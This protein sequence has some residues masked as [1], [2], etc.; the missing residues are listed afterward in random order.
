M[1]LRKAEILKKVGDSLGY[2]RAL[3]G[4]LDIAE[5]LDDTRLV[6]ELNEKLTLEYG[7]GDYL[8][9]RNLEAKKRKWQSELV[10]ESGVYALLDQSDG[11]LTFE[12][13]Y[14]EVI[15][16]FLK[17]KDDDDLYDSFAC[18]VDKKYPNNEIA[19]SIYENLLSKGKCSPN[20]FVLLREKYSSN[21][22][23]RFLSKL[24]KIRLDN[25]TDVFEELLLT[26]EFFKEDLS[27]S[28]KFDEEML[29]K[30]LTQ[31]TYDLAAPVLQKK[32]ISYEG[33]KNANGLVRLLYLVK[34]SALG[35]LRKRNVYVE[36]LKPLHKLKFQGKQNVYGDFID[37]IVIKS[38]NPPEL[39]EDMLVQFND[40]IA[41]ST[42]ADLCKIIFEDPYH[43]I[44]LK[45]DYFSLLQ[46]QGDLLPKFY[47]KA[48]SQEDDP[49][50]AISF[51][52][53]SLNSD[54]V[55]HDVIVD[56][57]NSIL[58]QPNKVKLSNLDAIKR[59]TEV[60]NLSSVLES[61]CG[62]WILQDVEQSKKNQI[63]M[64]LFSLWSKKW[65]EKTR[66][67][68]LLSKLKD[69]NWFDFAKDKLFAMIGDFGRDVREEVFGQVISRN[70][71]SIDELDNEFGDYAWYAGSLEENAL[72]KLDKVT[73]VPRLE[74]YLQQMSVSNSI[75]RLNL[76]NPIIS[77]LMGLSKGR[78]ASE[79]VNVLKVIS[80]KVGIDQ[81]ETAYSDSVTKCVN[82]GLM[83]YLDIWKNLWSHLGEPSP[84]SCIFT[85]ILVLHGIEYGYPL[86]FSLGAITRLDI[87]FSQRTANLKYSVYHALGETDLKYDL[88][89]RD[90]Q[91]V[92]VS[93]NQMS[94]SPFTE[95]TIRR[96]YDNLVGQ[97]ALE[98]ES[99]LND[100][101]HMLE[102][103]HGARDAIE[104]SDVESKADAVPSYDNQV[105]ESEESSTPAMEF[106]LSDTDT[107]VGA[108]TSEVPSVL[109]NLDDDMSE[110][111]YEVENAWGDDDEESIKT[112]M[113]SSIITSHEAFPWRERVKNNSVDDE[114]VLRLLK[115]SNP[116]LDKHLGL[117]VISMMTGNSEALKNWPMAVWR[118]FYY[119]YYSKEV[120]PRFPDSAISKNIVTPA[121]KSI[122]ELNA[123]FVRAFSKKLVKS[124]LCNI[125]GVSVNEIENNREKLE[126]NEGVLDRAGLGLF[127][128]I[129]KSKKYL[130]YSIK[131]LSKR[132][133]YDANE[134]AFYIDKE[135]YNSVPPSHLL[136]RILEKYWAIRLRYFAFME[137]HPKL[138]VK[139][140]L[141][142]LNDELNKSSFS[143]LSKQSYYQKS[144]A[145]F[146]SS[147]GRKEVEN[148]LQPLMKTS[149]EEITSIQHNFKAHLYKIVLA[150]TLDFVG[151]CESLSDRNLIKSPVRNVQELM[152]LSRYIQPLIRFSLKMTLDDTSG[153]F[154]GVA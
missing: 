92:I 70:I 40:S 72:G 103:E 118:N 14:S 20:A 107:D 25:I 151:V 134:K 43:V 61:F 104:V 35:Y 93:S 126:W 97:F 135:Y 139:K 85:E 32:I 109:G 105:N 117:Q 74:E 17:L 110:S 133:F 56:I 6:H 149:S 7:A 154:T 55:N 46:D 8:E 75:S 26:E 77:K 140:A 88:L 114:A 16:T 38:E 66:A 39:A 34:S 94:D 90:I 57:L 67:N 65:D 29:T 31:D 47:V 128:D 152:G 79:I 138:E 144:A 80:D 81:L 48:A 119:A 49:N 106:D 41:D 115:A 51:L 142:T 153:S 19:V 87:D 21:W 42:K 9:R 37:E 62:Y 27:Y 121:A 23:K 102:G 69:K 60:V 122:V 59:L 124:G 95:Q 150:Q 108:D 53:K 129:L 113:H 36:I 146:I 64:T 13:M 33:S 4:C 78:N 116:Q 130:A 24:F 18:E 127:G 112:G 63:R 3:E 2:L 143:I 58:E 15:L 30:I 50:K 131:G 120:E 123:Y 83:D 68:W 99:R 147:Y 84:F 148:L 52:T 73:S 71:F 98:E 125:L 82:E 101:S 11:L 141:L 1:K 22:D 5:Q 100:S 54:Q 137:L 45:I 145:E 10:D 91:K 28:E 96:D 12:A 111:G 132:I 76:S 89:K 44:D 136:A 86:E